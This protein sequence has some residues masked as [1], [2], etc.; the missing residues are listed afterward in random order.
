MKNNNLS[1]NKFNYKKGLLYLYVYYLSQT[2]YEE[3]NGEYEDLICDDLV[4]ETSY[5]YDAEDVEY[6]DEYSVSLCEHDD[7][8]NYF[9][10]I[11]NE[12]YSLFYV[13]I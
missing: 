2:L 4:Y 9:Q 6:K 10:A 11:T 5:E 7:S 8:S 13:Y 12:I 3:R 1:T